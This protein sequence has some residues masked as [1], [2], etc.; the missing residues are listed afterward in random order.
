MGIKKLFFTTAAALMMLG[1]G[2]VDAQD[3]GWYM[4]AGIGLSH[5]SEVASCSTLRS[6]FPG[7]PCHNKNTSTGAKLS[8]GYQFNE[9]VALEVSYVNLGKFTMSSSGTFGGGAPFTASGSDKVSGFSVD[10]VRTWPMTSKF[11]ALGRVGVFRWT[12][13]DSTS[14]FLG[15]PIDVSNKPSG[16]S[17]D[18][19]VGVKYDIDG[20]IGARAELQRFQGIGNSTTGKSDVDSISASLVYRFR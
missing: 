18:F 1:H 20:N 5:V 11:G 17:L 16:N 15:G 8:G 14:M 9:D 19:G 13:D 10:I 7:F 4:G 6:N 2:T 12:L 3:Q